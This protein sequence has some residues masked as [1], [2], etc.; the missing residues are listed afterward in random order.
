MVKGLLLPFWLVYATLANAACRLI[1]RIDDTG[2]C[3]ANVGMI[4]RR[5]SV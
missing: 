1:D 2:V 3:Y 5:K 4:A